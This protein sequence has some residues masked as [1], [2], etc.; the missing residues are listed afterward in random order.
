MLHKFYL[1]LRSIS[2]VSTIDFFTGIWP[3]MAAVITII[4]S[5]NWIYE[6]LSASKVGLWIMSPIM[7]PYVLYGLYKLYQDQDFLKLIENASKQKKMSDYF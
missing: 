1:V 7:I 2:Y 4:K 3:F 5:R 6:K